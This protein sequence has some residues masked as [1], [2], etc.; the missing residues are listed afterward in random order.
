MS[1]SDP[2]AM[3]KYFIEQLN[4]KKVEFLEVCEGF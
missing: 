4:K 2:K 1:D 3:L